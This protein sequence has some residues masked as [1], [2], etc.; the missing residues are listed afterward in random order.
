MNVFLHVLCSASYHAAHYTL[1][2]SPLSRGM[3]FMSPYI[4]EA[5]NE[6][7]IDGALP[8]QNGALRHIVSLK[9]LLTGVL[10]VKRL[11]DAGLTSGKT[12]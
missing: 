6:A 7:V 8:A 5:C 4:G 2:T 10:G 1:V 11:I 3:P 12:S 9:G